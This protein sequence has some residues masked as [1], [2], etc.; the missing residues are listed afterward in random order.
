[1]QIKPGQMRFKSVSG[2]IWKRNGIVKAHYVWYSMYDDMTLDCSNSEDQPQKQLQLT[3]NLQ[4]EY[5]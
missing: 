1:M 3:A 5:Q 2:G 4:D